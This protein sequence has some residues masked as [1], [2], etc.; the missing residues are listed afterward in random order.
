MDVS[1][2]LVDPPPLP[3]LKRGSLLAVGDSG[4]RWFRCNKGSRDMSQE[5][6][7]DGWKGITFKAIIGAKL[8]TF[9]PHIKLYIRANGAGIMADGSTKVLGSDH[10]LVVV[11]NGNGMEKQWPE[12]A[13]ST[14]CEIARL[15][16]YFARCTIIFTIYVWDLPE[17]FP[18]N[19]IRMLSLIHIS[20]PTRPY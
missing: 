1:A 6:E 14:L 9:I 4:F 11:Y 7:D 5:F 19:M 2:T 20:E 3:A 18:Q 15:G 17:P 16:Q 8:E 13:F 12:D 10:S